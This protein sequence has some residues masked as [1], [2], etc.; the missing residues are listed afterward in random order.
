MLF[1]EALSHNAFFFL[2]TGRSCP[3]QEYVAMAHRV[4]SDKA[5][6]DCDAQAKLTTLMSAATDRQFLRV[7]FFITTS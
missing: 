7:P 3:V 6:A 2:A 1:S 4:E 5:Q